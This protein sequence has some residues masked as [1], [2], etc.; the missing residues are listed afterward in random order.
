MP[1]GSILITSAPK[2]ASNCPQNGP[3]NNWPVSITRIPCSGPVGE[4]D[5]FPPAQDCIQDKG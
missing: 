1:G 2:S 5:I 4:L 3:A